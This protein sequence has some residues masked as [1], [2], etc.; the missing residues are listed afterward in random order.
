[1]CQVNDLSEMTP[2]NCWGFKA[3]PRSV[4]YAVAWDKWQ[5]FYNRNKTKD[6][7]ELTKHSPVV[8]AW[9]KLSSGAKIVKSK[10]KT[11]YEV[12]AMR[13]C[14]SVFDASGKYF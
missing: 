6:V 4:L 10:Q 3:Y 9:N 5:L 11:A 2:E 8:H 7:I 12:I 1:M 13:N 14:P